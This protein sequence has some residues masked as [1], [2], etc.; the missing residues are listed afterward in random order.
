MPGHSAAGLAGVLLPTL[1]LALFLAG[2][3]GPASE[4]QRPLRS[5]ATTH[6]AAGSVVAA[7]GTTRSAQPAADVVADT[8]PATAEPAPS[9]PVRFASFED[10]ELFLPSRQTMIVGFHEASYGSALRLRPWGTPL[11]SD[12]PR[13]EAAPPTDPGP[14]YAV[15]STRSR[16]TQATSAADI[17]VPPGT[18]IA[19]PVTGTVVSVE[20]YQLYGT[21]PDLRIRIRPAGRPDIL[22]TVL[23]VTGAQVAVGDELVGGESPLA[24][25]ATHF[26]F[27]SHVDGY[28]GG[29]PPHVHVEARRA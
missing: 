10:V 2:S 12:N 5:L 24:T 17:A 19:S 28:S 14:N 20:P 21:Y 11:A 8:A 22:V 25:E 1:L 27:R 7:G 4:H 3:G 29:R 23:H 9:G 26:P 18:P 6:S 15:M 13:K 16:P